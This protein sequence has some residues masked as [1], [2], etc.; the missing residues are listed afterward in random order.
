MP[1]LRRL[2]RRRGVTMYVS[3]GEVAPA[4]RS[5]AVTRIQLPGQP[6][7][8]LNKFALGSSML[9]DKHYHQIGKIARYVLAQQNTRSPIRWIHA[10]GHTDPVGSDERNC[11]LGMR[12]ARAVV[13][14]LMDVIGSRNGGRIPEQLGVLRET[15]GSA[16]P[17]IGDRALSR[18]VEIF[19]LRSRAFPQPSGKCPQPAW[20]LCAK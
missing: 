7:D 9:T 10:V 8:V 14:Q 4:R 11:R 16:E 13:I 18:R 6:Y 3:L 2:A 12:R 19:L 5:Q 17:V 15:R 1:M 20:C